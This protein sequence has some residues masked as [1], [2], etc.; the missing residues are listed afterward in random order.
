MIFSVIHCGAHG[1]NAFNFS[2]YFNS[3]YTDLNVAAYAN[4]V[5]KPSYILFCPPYSPANA[6]KLRL[7]PCSD[8]AYCTSL[9][10][11]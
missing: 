11:I 2:K 1:F 9:V 8:W 5:S 4:Q 6:G 3:K 7:E 10:E